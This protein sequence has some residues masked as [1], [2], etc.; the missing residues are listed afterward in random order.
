[1]DSIPKTLNT[2]AHAHMS[3]AADITT[4]DN[5]AYVR[6]L[7]QSRGAAL[8]AEAKQVYNFLL[9]GPQFAKLS[10]TERGLVVSFKQAIDDDH[11]AGMHFFL[12]CMTAHS[13]GFYHYLCQKVALARMDPFRDWLKGELDLLLVGRGGGP[14]GLARKY[15]S[16]PAFVAAARAKFESGYDP[17]GKARAFHG[18]N[19]RL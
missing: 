6:Q 11:A 17:F 13:D 4:S 7:L 16:I 3:A 9:T 1:M 2:H 10:P 12:L 8:S 15:R 18:S 14:D 19:R 5:C